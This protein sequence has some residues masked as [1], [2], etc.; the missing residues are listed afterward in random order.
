[1]K[2]K[3]CLDGRQGKVKL[4]CGHY[5]CS[6]CALKQRK[7]QTEETYDMFIC[8]ACGGIK[9]KIGNLFKDSR[10]Y[11]LGMWKK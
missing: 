10:M 1:M 11:C 2:N 5:I 4:R 8:Y 6:T 9:L 3:F 7:K